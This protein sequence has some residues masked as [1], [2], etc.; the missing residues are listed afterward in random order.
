[1]CGYINKD[2]GNDMCNNISKFRWIVDEKAIFSFVNVTVERLDL[3]HARRQLHVGDFEFL[4]FEQ[5][6]RRRITVT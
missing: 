2:S 1:M 3:V 4:I 5:L 6:T